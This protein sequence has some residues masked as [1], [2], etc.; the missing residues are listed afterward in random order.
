MNPIPDD[1]EMIDTIRGLISALSVT[2]QYLEHPDVVVIPFAAP[3]K[4]AADMARA[5]L[6][7]AR[8]VLYRATIED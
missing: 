4:G 6:D 5:A 1:G 7:K 3:S 2:V 8:D